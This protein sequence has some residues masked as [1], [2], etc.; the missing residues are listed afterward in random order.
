M[1]RQNE[2]K[3]QNIQCTEA[4]RPVEL[5][6]VHALHYLELSQHLLTHN[7]QMKRLE[8]KKVGADRQEKINAILENSTTPEEALLKT[9]LI[10]KGA[11]GEKG[12]V[13]LSK[14]RQTHRKAAEK[15]VQKR[16]AKLRATCVARAQNQYEEA[17]LQYRKII[18]NS[19]REDH[20]TYRTVVEILKE[21]EQKHP[22]QK[23]NMK[24]KGNGQQGLE[25]RKLREQVVAVQTAAFELASCIRS[26]RFTKAIVELRPH[27]DE[28]TV[29]THKCDSPDCRGTINPEELFV[30]SHCGHKACRACLQRRLS[31]FAC[32]SEGCGLSMQARDLIKPADIEPTIKD[33]RNGEY[34]RK[35]YD[36]C[37]L[38]KSIP[39]ND[40]AILF[41]PNEEAVNVMEEV[42]KAQGIK[43]DAVSRKQRQHVA[44]K[45]EKF[46]TDKDPKTMRKVLVLNLM[47]ELAAGANLANANHVIFASPLLAKDQYEYD[48]AMTQAIARC[49]RYGQE[50][51]VHVYHFAALRTVDVDILEHRHRLS[52]PLMGGGPKVLG[53][54]DG[55]EKQKKEQSRMV[56]TAQGFL[57]L[58]PLSLL[59]DEETGKSVDGQL[60]E[61]F[62]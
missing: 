58:V 21:T 29:S 5:G 62:T 3:L 10:H 7:M 20:E 49:R 42:L 17:Y 44:K 11:D 9:A 37:Q 30:S 25:D 39:E 23:S 32:V 52:T 41:M 24:E 6:V 4:F 50:K 33:A 36:V 47:S 34:G 28:D 31:D 48:S 35:I 53:E 59:S 2:P 56:R 51:K 26:E 1:V 8:K 18:V 22:L 13:S 27:E 43:H 54:S 55:S 46:Q 16:A 61:A 14:K 45:M 15:E 19:L 38:L 60:E 57:V 40:Q 12:L